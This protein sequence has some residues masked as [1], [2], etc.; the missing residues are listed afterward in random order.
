[1]NRPGAAGGP[2]PV[3]EVETPAFDSP[4]FLPLA[5]PAPGLRGNDTY[6]L[7]GVALPAPPDPLVT[8]DDGELPAPPV[9]FEAAATFEGFGRERGVGFGVAEAFE[10]FLA[11]CLPR[12]MRLG[13][14]AVGVGIADVGVVVGFVAV[15]GVLRPSA[16][17]E[18]DVVSEETAVTIFIPPPFLPLRFP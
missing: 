13:A 11:L 3:A 17:E 4:R 12:G 18:A 2:T 6:G 5:P 15:A 16:D 9:V 14:Y 8:V 10:P 1:M 7:P